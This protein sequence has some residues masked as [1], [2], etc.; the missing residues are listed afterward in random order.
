MMSL[1]LHV[2]QFQSPS[3]KKSRRN[4]ELHSRSVCGSRLSTQPYLSRQADGITDDSHIAGC[5]SVSKTVLIEGCQRPSSGKGWHRY[6]ASRNELSI[7]QSAWS[8]PSNLLFSS[9]NAATY[10]ACVDPACNNIQTEERRFSW[11]NQCVNCG[12]GHSLPT[13]RPAYTTDLVE[14]Q[15]S[16]QRGFDHRRGSQRK[17]IGSP[18]SSTWLE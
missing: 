7:Q 18:V 5:P 12:F 16:G 6:R 2:R 17:R 3:T 8:P 4:F 10:Q 11:R 13:P 15:S 1:T 9:V 14:P